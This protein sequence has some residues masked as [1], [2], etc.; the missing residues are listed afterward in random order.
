MPDARILDLVAQELGEL[1]LDLVADALRA[2][3][4]LFHAAVFER[5]IVGLWARDSPSDQ[6]LEWLSAS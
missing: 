6:L 5:G 1:L 4:V 3:G 2:L